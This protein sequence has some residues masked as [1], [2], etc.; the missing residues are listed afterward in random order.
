MPSS[1]N[2]CLGNRTQGYTLTPGV[3]VAS[4]TSSLVLHGHDTEQHCRLTVAFC[5]LTAN[6]VEVNLVVYLPLR[7]AVI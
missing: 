7:Q 1:T 6:I 4:T 3:N 2:T 5:L